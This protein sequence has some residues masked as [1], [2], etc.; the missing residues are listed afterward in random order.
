METI[1]EAWIPVEYARP[2]SGNYLHDVRWEYKGVRH[3]KSA[4]YVNGKW[5]TMEGTELVEPEKGMV[6]KL[7]VYNA[8]SY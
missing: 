8:E 1:H 4:W 3:E 2:K 5:R 6:W 7:E